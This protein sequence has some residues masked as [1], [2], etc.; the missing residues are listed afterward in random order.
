VLNDGVWVRPLDP[1]AMLAA[2]SYRVEIDTVVQVFDP[3]LGD[4]RLALRGGPDGASCE[5][6]DQPAQVSFSLAA[7]GSAYLGGH[8]LHIL[9]RA[10]ALRCDDPTLLTRLELAL[11]TER[12]PFHGTSF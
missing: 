3:L 5:P 9:E 4:R 12:E 8:R 7:L 11:S 1:A 10:G 6:T 2:R